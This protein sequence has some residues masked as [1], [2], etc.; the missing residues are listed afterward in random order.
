MIITAGISETGTT[1]FRRWQC[2]VPQRF[3]RAAGWRELPPNA[4]KSHLGGGEVSRVKT[5]SFFA[6]SSSR[7][8]C[9]ES[10]EEGERSSLDVVVVGG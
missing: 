6:M 8:V 3:F 4:G 5:M 2:R 7:S 9:R 10:E 1:A